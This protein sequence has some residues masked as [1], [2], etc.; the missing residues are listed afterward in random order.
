MTPESSS[1]ETS[2]DVIGIEGMF[3]GGC[4]LRGR[5]AGRAAA[6]AVR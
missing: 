4:L 1:A 2:A 6:Q 3:P 5:I